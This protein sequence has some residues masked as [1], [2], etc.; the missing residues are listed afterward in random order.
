MSSQHKGASHLLCIPWRWL[1]PHTQ[2]ERR[3]ICCASTST[4]WWHSRH[5]PLH[6]GYLG[7]LGALWETDKSKSLIWRNTQQKAD[8]RRMHVSFSMFW[9]NSSNSPL[10]L[11]SAESVRLCW[12]SSFTA[13]RVQL[14]AQPSKVQF[15]CF[16]SCVF[17]GHI[18][19]SKPQWMKTNAKSN[20]FNANKRSFHLLGSLFWPRDASISHNKVP[21]KVCG[22]LPGHYQS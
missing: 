15:F 2:E 3:N 7:L 14:P 13:T 5:G 6:E 17:T 12:P 11:S 16:W 4:E 8:W 1:P 18:L 19:Q 10:W 9:S 20:Q 21:V 22:V